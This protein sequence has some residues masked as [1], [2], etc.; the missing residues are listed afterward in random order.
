MAT[1]AIH[2]ELTESYSTDSFFQAM[3]RFICAHGTPSRVQLDCGTQL[4]AAAKEV[5]QWDFSG[6]QKVVRCKEI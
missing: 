1:S 5:A 6:I 3:R 2:L 4:I